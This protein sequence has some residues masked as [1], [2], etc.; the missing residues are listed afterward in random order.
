VQVLRFLR[1]S[2]AILILG[3]LIGGCAA[4]QAG[5]PPPPTQD[6][7]FLDRAARDGLAE[8]RLARLAADRATDPR[9]QD[10][11]QAMLA[12][13]AA[14]NELLGRVAATLGLP[15]P[16]DLDRAESWD[17]KALARLHGDDLHRY[18]VNMMAEY[19][20]KEVRLFRREVGRAADSPL[21]RFAAAT[22]P[23]LKAGRE[24]AQRL[25]PFWGY[26]R[27]YGGDTPQ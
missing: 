2:R 4:V 25:V 6:E 16:Q 11:A 7:K 9:V 19:H 8:V 17:Y 13:F 12:D 20:V 15:L 22:L 24:K 18:Y 21:R 5:S 27:T 14:S 10:L 23:A 3:P 1:S 26:G